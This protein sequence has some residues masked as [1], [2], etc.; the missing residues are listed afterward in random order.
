MK[1]WFI[2]GVSS[3]LGLALAKAVDSD[4]LYMT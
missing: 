3:G 2:T 4:G 1:T